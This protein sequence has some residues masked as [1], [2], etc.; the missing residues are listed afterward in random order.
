YVVPKMSYDR[1]PVEA[2]V[3]ELRPR[4]KSLNITFKVVEK[5][6]EREVTSRRDG[7]THRV[8]DAVAGDTTGTVT[9][10]LWDDM[11]ETVEVDKT[12]RLENGYTSLYQG[13]LRLNIGRYGELKEAD[14]SIDEVDMDNDLSS[15]EHERPPRRSYG[16]Y[17]GGR[18]YGGG[19]GGGYRR[20]RGD[21]RRDRGR[22]Y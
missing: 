9:M 16:G 15:M 14:A 12:Y 22:R 6:E 8:L 13:H 20:D 3:A 1:E 2:T 19:R 17:G 21:S 10:S 7:E 4:M 5:G 11:I 18:S